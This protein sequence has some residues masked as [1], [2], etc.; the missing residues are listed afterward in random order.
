MENKKV[1]NEISNTLRLINYNRGLT[2]LE[3]NS[4]L[5]IEGTEYPIDFGRKN[6]IN[7]EVLRSDETKYKNKCQPGFNIIDPATVKNYFKMLNNPL[8]DTK[9]SFRYYQLPSGD[10]CEKQVDLK[11][12]EEFVKELVELA[13]YVLPA[14]AI[15]LQMFGGPPGIVAGVILELGDAAL[16]EFYDHDH[17]AAG[18]AFVFAFA[19]PLDNF[20]GP[21]GKRALRTILVKLMKKQAMTQAEKN[22]IKYTVTNKKALLRLTRLGMFRKIL[23][24]MFY[25]ISN[26]N[27]FL[28]FISFLIKKGVLLS[29]FLTRIGLSIGV[30]FVT[31]DY[32]AKRLEICRSFSISDLEKADWKILKII[33][34]SGKYLQPYTTSCD[35]I[36]FEKTLKDLEPKSQ[37]ND[38][39]VTL[40]DELIKN[41]VVFNETNKD[42]EI[43]EICL[44]QF[45]LTYFGFSYFFPEQ[46]KV[47][48]SIE[49]GVKWDK[50][51][52]MSTYLKLDMFALSKHPECNQYISPTKQISKETE[53]LLKSKELQTKINYDY[54]KKTPFKWGYYDKQTKDNV[55]EFQ[56]KYLGIQ[57]ADGILGPQ[58]F[59]K[60]IDLINNLKKQ[61]PNYSNRDWSMEEIK[62]LREEFVEQIEQNITE[63][64]K[65]YGNIPIEDIEEAYVDKKEAL[66]DSVINEV[67]YK[68]FTISDS[69]LYE[70]KNFNFD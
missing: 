59:K 34:K 47:D 51:K 30:P 3:N 52:C 38:R 17:Y 36:A 50:N 70:I 58:T 22:I 46:K 16:Y 4:D 48:I 8:T 11:N 24:D 7:Y 40:L 26:L 57:S 66:K 25:K 13:H 1:I 10:W 64:D 23:Q 29:S 37:M 54:G 43:Y 60:M 49:K 12:T 20:L 15:C 14:T 21:L 27:L 6:A 31:F 2:I 56:K 28:K 53:T 32:I 35:Q 39:L 69:T 41:K 62:K 9:K 65:K 45:I 63:N 33:G 18:I 55:F 5:I 42:N 67:D 68:N 19:G 44:L 61:I